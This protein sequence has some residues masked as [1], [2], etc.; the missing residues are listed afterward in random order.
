MKG[1]RYIDFAIQEKYWYKWKH[2]GNPY[3]NKGP[4]LFVDLNGDN[5]L[6]FVIVCIHILLMRWNKIVWSW[7]TVINMLL[8][9]M[10]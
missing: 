8:N 2:S 6:Y 9:W 10:F 7:D 3:N 4:P 5:Q 1:R